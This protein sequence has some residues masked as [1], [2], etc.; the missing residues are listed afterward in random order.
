[1]RKDYLINNLKT[2]QF[3]ILQLFFFVKYFLKSFVI[4]HK[5][6]FLDVITCLYTVIKL[7]V[8]Y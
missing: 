6:F 5:Y 8:T 4:L 2:I 3:V 7:Y 1:M